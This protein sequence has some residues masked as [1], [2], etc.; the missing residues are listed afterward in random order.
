MKKQTSILLATMLLGGLLAGCGNNGNHASNSNGSS[1]DTANSANQQ[2]STGEEISGTITYLSN[3]TD[4]IGNTYDE[5]AKRF[6]E[7]YPNAHVEFEAIKDFDQ[8]AKVR[9]SSRDLPDVMNIPT[10]SNAE[11]PNYYAPLDDLGLNDRIRFKDYKSFEGKVYGIAS[12]VETVGIVYNKKAFADAGITEIPT[13]LD[14]FYAAADKLKAKGVVPFASNFKEQWPLYPFSKEVPIAIAGDGN[15]YNDRVKSDTPYTLEGP[16]GESM[17]II[18]TMYEK[19][20]LEA[21]VNSTNWEQSKKDFAT[22]KFAMMYLGQWIIPQLISAGTTSDN[23]G[24]FPF[25]YNNESSHNTVLSPSSGVYG[26]NKDSKNIAVAKA[27]VKWMLE[28]SGAG[29]DMLPIFKDAQSALPQLQEYES[30]KPNYIELT[31]DTIESTERTNKAQITKEA[32]VQEFVLAKNPQDVFDDY[33][34]KWTEAK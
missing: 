29:D 11:L 18:R 1:T 17:S 10:I 12:G 27:F 22:G 8:N 7:K 9:L 5:Y 16:F 4:L 21:D 24:F 30:F 14:A 34:K 31:P 28:E 32:I 26:V 2:E 6:N 23:V 20:Y 3:R 15:F 33:N 13:T 25:P 19:G